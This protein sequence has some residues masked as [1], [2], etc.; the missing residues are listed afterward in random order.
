MAGNEHG[1]N[2]ADPRASL[3]VVSAGDEHGV[4]IGIAKA[5]NGAVKIREG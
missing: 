5:A 3:N 2:G 1:S 4:A